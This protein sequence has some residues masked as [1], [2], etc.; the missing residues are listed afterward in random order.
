MWREMWN[1]LQNFLGTKQGPGPECR[2]ELWDTHAPRISDRRIALP[3]FYIKGT[4]VVPLLCY[5]RWVV[6][7]QPVLD[8]RWG[9][10]A[11]PWTRRRRRGRLARRARRAA[12]NRAPQRRQPPPGHPAAAAAGPRRRRPGGA[13]LLAWHR[14]RVICSR[15]AVH[16]RRRHRC[17]APGAASAAGGGE[18][19]PVLGVHRPDDPGHRESA[20]DNQ[21][22]P[23][24]LEQ[25]PLQPNNASV[26]ACISWL[27]W[28]N[29]EGFPPT[30]S[31][32]AWVEQ[33]L[34]GS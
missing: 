8:G 23:L 10:W 18:Q 14:R 15:R 32:R 11:A 13:A 33:N 1:I 6:S 12:H 34:G 16:Q 3:R 31:I 19:G 7:F 26:G 5:L 9:L 28:W 4:S 27:F 2:F 25:Q 22:V 24:E 29:Q 30:A 21:A 17:R 20:V